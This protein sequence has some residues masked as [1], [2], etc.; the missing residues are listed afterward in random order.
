MLIADQVGANKSKL[1]TKTSTFGMWVPVHNG[2]WDGD[3]PIPMEKSKMLSDKEA[4]G[5]HIV[6]K[7][8]TL[9]W[10]VGRYEVGP[11]QCGFWA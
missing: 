9:P 10:Q 7:G 6:F 8:D 5:G 11:T 4:E 3:V 2:E 1:V